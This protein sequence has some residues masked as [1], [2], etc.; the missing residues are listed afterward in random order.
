MIFKKMV[1]NLNVFSSWM[2]YQILSDSYYTSTI[3]LTLNT[4]KF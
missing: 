3:I 1:P 2:E 4:T